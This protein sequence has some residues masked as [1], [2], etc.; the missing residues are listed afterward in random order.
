ME[1]NGYKLY[2]K[3]WETEG[4]SSIWEVHVVT[5]PYVFED[6]E[7]TRFPDELN[8]TLDSGVNW[9]DEYT[10]RIRIAN[11]SRALH[12]AFSRRDPAPSPRGRFG[13]FIS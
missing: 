6:G 13:P 10:G 7:I 3:P 4:G 12:P 1:I 5:I 11:G 9:Q 2:G 8:Y